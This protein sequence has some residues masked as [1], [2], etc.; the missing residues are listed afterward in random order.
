MWDYTDAVKSFYIAPKNAG[1]MEDADVVAEVGSIVC[2]DALKLYLKLNDDVIT[3]AKFTVFGCGSAIAASSALTELLKGKTMDEAAKITNVQI[4]D[5]LGGLPAEKMHCSVMGKEAVDKA[6]RM[7]KGEAV[8]EDTD[9]DGV[10]ICQC[11]GI[12]DT[13]IRKVVRRNKL[14]SVK[15]VTDY[16]KAGGACGA[17]MH[18]I[19]GILDEELAGRRL[20]EAA[21]LQ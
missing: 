12:T 4:A 2:G 7:W 18:K 10:I 14:S 13:M 8:E 17:C 11:F 3:D 19:Q 5:F 9:T 15:D 20:A 6:V 21:G 16:T 1:V